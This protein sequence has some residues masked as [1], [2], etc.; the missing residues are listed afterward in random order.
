MTLCLL[1]KRGFPLFDNAFTGAGAEA[2]PDSPDT[3]VPG[4]ALAD[5]TGRKAT[6]GLDAER[7]QDV[8]RFPP[9]RFPSQRRREPPDRAGT[10]AQ[11][12]FPG[13]AGLLTSAPYMFLYICSEYLPPSAVRRKPLINDK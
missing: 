5:M 11:R 10:R 1:R 9:H 8:R 12:R 3:E 7:S 6:V 2:A 4:V 13:E